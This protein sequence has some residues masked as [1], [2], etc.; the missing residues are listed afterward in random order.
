VEGVIVFE[1]AC[2]RAPAGWG[3]AFFRIGVSDPCRRNH[4]PPFVQLS[5]RSSTRA[6]GVACSIRAKKIKFC[7][8]HRRFQGIWVAKRG[9]V[10]TVEGFARDVTAQLCAN[11][12]DEP[13]LAAQACHQVNVTR[14]SYT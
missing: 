10:T 14:V 12:S 5:H 6:A 1:T 13:R 4:Q 7:R 8:V 3:F 2:M 9:C 11:L